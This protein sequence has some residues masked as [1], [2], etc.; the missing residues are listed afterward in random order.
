MAT[1]K[2]QAIAAKNEGNKA[3]AAHDWVKAVAC[4]DKAIELYDEEPTFYTNRAQVR[5]CGPASAVLCG[6]S[7]ALRKPQRSCPLTRAC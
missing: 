6:L 3:F 2:E 5:Q 1:P 4:Y 7:R